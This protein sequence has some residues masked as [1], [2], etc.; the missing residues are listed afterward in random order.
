MVSVMILRITFFGDKLKN[1]SAAFQNYLK[2][3]LKG[4]E[5][6][7]FMNPSYFSQSGGKA[8][9]RSV[10]LN[11][12][13]MASPYY[14]ITDMDIGEEVPLRYQKNVPEQVYYYMEAHYRAD[15]PGDTMNVLGTYTP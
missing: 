10:Q 14:L 3:L 12:T 13:S 6:L 5:D 1:R 4:G 15:C 9:F 2:K 11:N 7:W 8:D